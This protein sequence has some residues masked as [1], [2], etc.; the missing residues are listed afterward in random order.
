M[1]IHPDDRVVLMI[2]M[3][4]SCS[5][6][7]WDLQ[8]FDVKG[9]LSEAVLIE[10]TRRQLERRNVKC[11]ILQNQTKGTIAPLSACHNILELYKVSVQ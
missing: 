3:V 8:Y 10:S 4:G 5:P 2:A 6:T 9:T 7:Y 11:M 1:P